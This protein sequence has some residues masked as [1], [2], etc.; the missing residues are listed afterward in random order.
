MPLLAVLDEGA[1]G[2]LD[3][4]LKTLYVQNTENK[5]FYLDIAPD[6]A[7]KVAFTLQKNFDAKKADL[8]RV[9]REK[10]ELG[11]KVKAYESLGKSAEEIKAA[12]EAN[13]PEEVTK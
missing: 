10:T 3:E 6:E 5:N 11:N 4:S 13:R 8:D 1:H 12:L 2:A 9:H 7:A